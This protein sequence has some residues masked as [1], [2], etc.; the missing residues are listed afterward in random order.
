MKVDIIGGGIAGFSAAAE[1]KRINKDIKVTVH[2]KSSEIGYNHEAR[3]CGE[4]YNFLKEYNLEK[5]TQESIFCKVKRIE[6]EIKGKKTLI[7]IESLYVLNKQKFIRQIAKKAEKLGAEIST[8]DKIRT[9][10]K[11]KGNY[12]VDASGC[13]SFVKNKLN[14]G[15]GKLA[16]GYQHTLENSNI[17]DKDAVKVIFKDEAGYYWIFPR[18]PKK[19]EVNVGVGVINS[20]KCNLVKMLEKFK[21]EYKITG[22]KNYSTGGLIPLGLQRPLKYKN[23]LFVGD[24]GVG[25]FPIWAEGNYRANL[26]GKTAARCI[27]N[28]YPEKYP[29]ITNRHYIKWDTIGKFYLS[30]YKLFAK[31][32]P[33]AFH[34]LLRFV[35]SDRITKIMFLK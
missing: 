19:S 29:I 17:F 28:N 15:Y 21:N 1:L 10:K 30:T 27:A 16:I 33:R 13:P 25:T 18:D 6:L 31:I 12:I 20:N 9:L 5:P 8:N 23:I 34:Q 35:F 14:L 24:A 11:L 26:S 22:E 32:G 4:G 2:E 3:K 7:P